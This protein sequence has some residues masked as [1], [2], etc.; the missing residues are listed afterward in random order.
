M[1]SRTSLFV[2][3]ILIAMIAASLLTVLVMFL[4]GVI[5]K[6]KP[7]LEF[8]VREVEAKEYDG[9]PL[10]TKNFRWE[11]GF[12]N[13]KEG[14]RVEGEVRGS[15][16]NA[17][18][19]QSDLRVYVYDENDRDV[20][21]E[22]NIKVNN[23]DLTVIKRKISIAIDSQKIEYNGEAP[24]L[25]KYR[26]FDGYRDFVT[27]Y[28]EGEELINGQKLVISFPGKF[29]NVGDKLPP[30]DDWNVTKNFKIYDV[31]G[32]VV[33]NNYDI[34]F[35]LPNGGYN[36]EIV[37]RKIQVKALNTEKYYD[38]TPI[39]G[40][41]EVNGSLAD[42]EF[43]GEVKFEDIT[44]E[45]AFKPF[46]S[47]KSTKV[48]ITDIVIYRQEGF[49]LVPVDSKNYDWGD[50]DEI[51]TVEVKK[52]PI[53]V[54][55]K[56][57]VKVYDGKALSSLVAEDELPFTVTDLPKQFTLRGNLPVILE[58]ADVCDEAYKL[59]NITVLDENE[60]NVTNQFS[61]DQRSGI[62]RIT[63]ITI[64]VA[65]GE[66]DPATY[67]GNDITLSATAELTS[68]IESYIA[69]IEAGA[70]LSNELNKLIAK[71]KCAPSQ[72]KN[73]GT[74]SYSASITEP[75]KNIIVNFSLGSITVKPQEITASYNA[76]TV[77]KVYDG[78]EA[79]S[80]LKSSNIVLNKAELTVVEANFECLDDNATLCQNGQAHSVQ[81][82]VVRIKNLDG[83]DV[84]QNYKV[85]PFTVS[86]TITEKMIYASA[87]Q[88]VVYHEVDSLESVDENEIANLYKTSIRFEGLA[89]GDVIE[90]STL[91]IS[92]SREGN[93]CIKISV[94]PP[95]VINSSG[96]EVDDCY[97]FGTF[98]AVITV[99]LRVK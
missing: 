17:G 15:Q 14:H 89:E 44:T 5:A 43:I 47:V 16:I 97:E 94:A 62:A 24:V 38:G 9:E 81:G 12:T 96:T 82:T 23:C 65:L 78:K 71:C 37:P 31:A 92:V 22:Y 57:L 74:Y 56:D 28:D 59:Q 84:T 18:T 99:Y 33:T 25:G 20:T 29:E 2:I 75:N 35:F 36:I 90:Y 49:N 4:T 80:V 32:N 76:E 69:N 51:A 54:T 61:I 30:Q 41:Y 91:I 63:P 77:S 68:A 83:E 60:K 42:K 8:T 55:A 58:N 39:E 79:S 72:V 7:L 95:T 10:T 3:G 98:G 27:E 88:S 13:L 86:V 34:R 48:K 64:Q 40:K 66:K 26:I 93:D 73:V 85:Q 19:S 11:S 6:E 52:R 45:Q 53:T 46:A 21:D 67:T 1:K 87:G 50:A 70:A